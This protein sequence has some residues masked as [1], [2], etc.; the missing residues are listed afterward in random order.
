MAIWEFAPG[1]P[2]NAIFFGLAMPPCISRSAFR[3]CRRFEVPAVFAA[4]PPQELQIEKRHRKLI[5]ASAP[6]VSEVRTGGAAR[7]YELRK[8]GASIW[9]AVS[10]SAGV[11]T[12][13]G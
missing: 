11:S 7:V 1:S 12:P 8:R 13:R 4:S 5:F 2:W 10:R 6:L 3:Q 9:R